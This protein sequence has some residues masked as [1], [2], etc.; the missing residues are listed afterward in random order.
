S[1]PR[2]GR[3]GMVEDGGFE[4]EFAARDGS[5]WIIEISDD[6]QAWSELTRRRAEDGT[7]HFMDDAPANQG[8][9]FYR[10]RLVE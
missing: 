9:R 6:L 8:Q 7:V 4:F 1:G 3:L 10:L 5:E 2:L